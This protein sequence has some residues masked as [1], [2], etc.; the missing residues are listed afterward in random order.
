MQ[1]FEKIDARRHRLREI[2]VELN[3]IP[4]ARHK[5][6]TYVD[7]VLVLL[8]IIGLG[9]CRTGEVPPSRVFEF[10][11][12]MTAEKHGLLQLDLE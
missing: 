2:L 5:R 10:E 1:I 3:V 6:I 4:L 7:S 12:N 11:L 9:S 8:V